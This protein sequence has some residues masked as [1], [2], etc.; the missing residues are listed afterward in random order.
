[1]TEEVTKA[2]ASDIGVVVLNY[3]NAKEILQYLDRLKDNGAFEAIQVIDNCSTDDSFEKI[4]QY[5]SSSADSRIRVIRS[6]EN[7]GYGSG[8]NLGVKALLSIASPK[9]LL[10]SNPDVIFTQKTIEHL[11]EFLDE[12]D[13]YAAVAPK[14]LNL[15]G[16][17]CQSGWKLPTKKSLHL[18]N[19]RR[20]LRIVPDPTAYKE[21]NSF[22]GDYFDVDVLPG[23]LFLIRTDVFREVGGFDEDT[24][25]Y[26]EEKLLFAKVKNANYKCAVLTSDS[27]IHAHGTT[28]TKEISSVKKR[29]RMALDSDLIYCNKIL[30]VSDVWAKLY[31]FFYIISVDCFALELKAKHLFDKHNEEE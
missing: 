13:Q 26:G 25:L 18:S 7:G 8:N 16:E 1:M 4:K 24:F 12:H 10:I 3:N 22:K 5:E 20:C 2:S 31:V 23:S 15:A 28:I 19:L 9:Y 30:G 14:M 27:Y 17:I 29:Y 11:S 6:Q 21:L